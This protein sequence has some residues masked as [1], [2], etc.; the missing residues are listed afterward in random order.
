VALGARPS[1]DATV[2]RFE[3]PDPERF[4]CLGLAYQALAVGGTAPA[5]L[6]AANE[7]A[8]EAFVNEEIRLPDIARTI[9]AALDAV[10]RSGE[11]GS[12]SGI[13]AADADARTFAREFVRRTRSSPARATGAV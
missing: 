2:L 5:V 1:D 7:I 3:R 4:P 9:E 13:R 11:G 10:A 6:S 8:V 12:L